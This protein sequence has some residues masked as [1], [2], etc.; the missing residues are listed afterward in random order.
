MS[1]PRIIGVI[2][3]RFGSS[4]F[5]GKPLVDLLGKTMIYRV[6]EASLQ[7]KTLQKIIVATDDK[8]IAK[9]AE[10]AGALAIITNDYFQSGTDRIAAT[11]RLADETADII[12]N[13]QG[14]EP[15]IKPSVIDDLIASAIESNAEV[16]TLVTPIKSN[17]ELENTSVVKVA[18]AQNGRALYFSRSIIPYFRDAKLTQNFENEQ[19][20]R[21]IGIYA[22]RREVLERF[23]Q[24]PPSPLEL[25]EQLEQLRLLEDGAYYQCCK[26]LDAPIAVDTPNDADIVREILEKQII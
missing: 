23:V 18:L 25:A 11:I 3:A 5:P 20:F 10:N 6:V 17:E 14:D 16:T 12:V 9:E 13:I 19:Y 22:Y 4:R 26:I 7:A 24:L 1:K 2:P 21:H 8:C 15:L